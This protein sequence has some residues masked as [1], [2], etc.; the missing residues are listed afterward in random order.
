[1]KVELT[2]REIRL[3]AAALQN[4][5][6]RIAHRESDPDL[7]KEYEMLWIRFNRLEEEL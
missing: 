7:S 6:V 2:A 1:M 4:E 5:A 3:L